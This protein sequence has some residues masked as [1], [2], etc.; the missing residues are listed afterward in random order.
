MGGGD[1]FPNTSLVLVEHGYNTD[2]WPGSNWCKPALKQ[3]VSY[4]RRSIL[5]IYSTG[6]PV[7]VFSEF[8]YLATAQ[9]L[10]RADQ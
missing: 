8:V 10:W 1:G 4:L 6:E 5:F 3:Y 7:E 2:N 9:E